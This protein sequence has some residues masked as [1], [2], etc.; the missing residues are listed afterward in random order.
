MRVERWREKDA[1]PRAKISP[2]NDYQL[3]FL[4]RAS[5]YCVP[6]ARANLET[7]DRWKARPDWPTSPRHHSLIG[8][9]DRTHPV[10]AALSFHVLCSVCTRL[11]ASGSL[12]N[13]VPSRLSPI[14]P[15]SLHPTW[16]ISQLP[17]PFTAAALSHSLELYQNIITDY[18]AHRFTAYVCVCVRIIYVYARARIYG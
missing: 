11:H 1:A 18:A 14:L 16:P 15:S 8:P 9:R 3:L 13:P 12:D 10:M 6:V 5:L 7:K 2:V 4:S 17:P